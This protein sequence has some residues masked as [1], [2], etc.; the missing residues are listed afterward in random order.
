MEN[1]RNY[2]FDTFIKRATVQTGDYLDTVA[3]SYSHQDYLVSFY[4]NSIDNYQL[5]IES[6]G[7]ELKQYDPTPEQIEAMQLM[8][9]KA[10]I[11]IKEKDLPELRA[12]EIT[13]YYDYFGVKR[14]HFY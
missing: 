13:D 2:I 6:F 12:N 8:L 3:L 5:R 9:I 4:G 1:L 14:E 7:T 11:R 10:I